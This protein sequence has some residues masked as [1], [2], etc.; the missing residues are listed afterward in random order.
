MSYE[1]YLKLDIPAEFG[2]QDWDDEIFDDDF[3]YSQLNSSVVTKWGVTQFVIIDK[4]LDEVIKIPFTGCFATQYDYETGEYDYENAE[5]ECYTHNYMEIA[6]DIY[7]RAENAGVAEFFAKMT[8]I[9]ETK[10]GTPIFRQEYVTPYDD[11]ASDSTP[12]EDSLTLVRKNKDKGYDSY[13]KWSI[14]ENDWTAYAVDIYGFDYVSR[15]LD[16][17]LKEQNHGKLLDL[18]LGNYGWR[19]DGTPAILD[20]AGYEE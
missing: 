5:F 7:N 10:N 19:K 13:K 15:F 14:F 2:P 12:S 3:I 9:G 1:D 6:E 8:F 20:W 18:H 17:V 16:F 4:R 11:Y